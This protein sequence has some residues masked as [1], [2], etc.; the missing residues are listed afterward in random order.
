MWGLQGKGNGDIG[1]LLSG[2]PNMRIHT[3]KEALM[4]GGGLSE[5]EKRLCNALQNGLPIVARPYDKIGE[6][7]DSD[8]KTAIEQTRGL[9]KRG[10]V[11]RMGTVVNWRAIGR[12]GTLATAHV[13][14]NNLKK[15]IKAVNDLEGVSHNYLRG[16]HYNI[17]FTLQADSQKQ[18]GKILGDLS[19]QFGT[20]FYSLPVKRVFKLDVRF[21]AQSNG[22]KLLAGDR[23]P[24]DCG[25]VELEQTDR[26]I[27]A[28]LQ[29]GLEVVEQ[30]FDSLCGDGLTI[31]E[32]LSRIEKMIR[33]GVIYRVGAIVNHH[34]LGFTANAMFVCKAGKTRTVQVGEAI[35]DL[36]NVSHCYERIP[37]EGWPYNLFAMM[38]GK[39]LEDIRRLVEKF[40]KSQKIEIWEI[41][42]TESNLLRQ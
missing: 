8:E 34:K 11:R 6:S 18:I 37:F 30:P 36:Q 38:H 9:V 12:A 31:T 26:R 3:C 33:T 13:E 4:T 17:W 42:A 23:K 10:F 39:N 32:V 7:L 20:T 40:V 25:P 29:R 5:F 14:Q 41:L 2:R 22:I 19:K 1:R 16:H 21:D 24:E 28:G 27:L 15:V 35:A